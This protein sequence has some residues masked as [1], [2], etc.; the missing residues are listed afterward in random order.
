MGW[1]RA[2]KKVL[3]GLYIVNFHLSQVIV[4]HIPNDNGSS[5][6]TFVLNASKLQCTGRFSTSSIEEHVSGFFWCR[7]NRLAECEI[8][9]FR[10]VQ[11]R[12]C[13]SPEPISAKFGW[14]TSMPRMQDAWCSKTV[15]KC[16]TFS[17]RNSAKL[18][19][20]RS[21]RFIIAASL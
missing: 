19:A 9:N 10:L 18:V 6:S 20:R 11:N 8:A 21:S 3:Y 14:Q 16:S 2:V 7:L 17:R 5:V 1:K 4:Y 12:R 13:L 15:S